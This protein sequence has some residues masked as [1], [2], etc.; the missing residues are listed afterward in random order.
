M[1]VL[2]LELL[3]VPDVLAFLFLNPSIHNAILAND[4]Q[5]INEEDHDHHENDKPI[6][7][8]G[9]AGARNHLLFPC[10]SGHRLASLHGGGSAYHGR[11]YG[12]GGYL[13]LDILS[14]RWGIII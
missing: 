5:G 8:E 11:L 1:L 13:C 2:E 3:F 12:A 14:A 7:E 9:A 6:L 10:H 4:K